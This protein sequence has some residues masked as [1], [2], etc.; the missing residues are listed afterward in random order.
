MKRQVDVVSY[1]LENEDSIYHDSQQ[2]RQ[3]PKKRVGKDGSV[4]LNSKFD[5]CNKEPVYF[6]RAM[7]IV[8]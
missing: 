4:E 2:I 1:A 6:E 3:W 5:A 7:D 8:C